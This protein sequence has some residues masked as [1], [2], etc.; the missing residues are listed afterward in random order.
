MSQV[1][2]TTAVET[3]ARTGVKYS[4]AGLENDWKWG[5][6]DE[7]V[8]FAFFL[9]YQELRELAAQ[10]AIQRA[11]DGPAITW[12]QRILAQ[13]HAAYRD[14]CGMLVGVGEDEIDRVPF[15]E[16][17]PL[18]VVLGH[19]IDAE[20]GFLDVIRYALERHRSG[21]G[22]PLEMPEEDDVEDEIDY[23]VGTLEQILTNYDTLHFQI[24]HELASISDDELHMPSFFWESNPMEIRFRLHRFDAHLRQ[25][26]IQVEKTLEGIGRQSREA[27]RLVRMIYGALGEAEGAVIGTQETNAEQWR[28]AAEG[29]L[30]RAAEVA[31]A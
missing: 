26:T 2:L 1:L 15:P 24:L 19:I 17:W 6:Y 30:K 23:S 28:K 12:A 27:E 3:F 18:R 9:T 21:D 31:K 25:H 14:L 13:H 5:D 20:Q 7:G 22:R 29:I 8:R 4:D 16:E 10:T 11:I